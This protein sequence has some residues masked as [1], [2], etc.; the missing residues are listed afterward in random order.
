MILSILSS[1]FIPLISLHC[2]LFERISFSK[3]LFQ[4]S[5][6]RVLIRRNTH[7]AQVYINRW[8]NASLKQNHSIRFSKSRWVEIG[9]FSKYEGQKVEKRWISTSL[10]KNVSF[11][12]NCKDVTEIKNVLHISNSKFQKMLLL[13][14]T[15]SEFKEW[16]ICLIHWFW[17]SYTFWLQA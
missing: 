15:F 9:Y 10:C 8:P 13:N 3:K 1:W 14:M 17:N 5:E 6:K 12:K 7:W 4:K 16:N 11:A 2:W